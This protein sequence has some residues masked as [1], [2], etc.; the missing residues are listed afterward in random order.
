MHNL[1]LQFLL[2]TIAGW[3]QQSQQQVVAY[4][5]EENRVLREQLDGQLDG[6]RLRFTDDQRRRLA[7]RAK[8]LK[9]SQFLEIGTIVTPDTLLRWHR[10]LIAKKYDGSQ[11]KRR[12]PGRPRVAGEIES[13]VLRM[14]R[15]TLRWGYTRIRGALYHLGHEV[16]RNTVKRVLIEQG[17]EPAPG[18]V[19]Y[20][21]CHRRTRRPHGCNLRPSQGGTRGVHNLR[22]SSNRPPPYAT[23]TRAT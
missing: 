2:T 9:R 6:R 16:A 17:L 15:D 21:G 11:S 22:R 23:G 13:L 1:P 4:L 5:Q 19:S 18:C 12:S 14:A 3:I 7:V 8:N 20:F 10:K